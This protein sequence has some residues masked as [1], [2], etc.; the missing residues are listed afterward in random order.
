[1]ARMRQS[2]KLNVAEPIT[3]GN[4]WEEPRVDFKAPH[5]R[6]HSRPC[7]GVHND[8][9]SSGDGEMTEHVDLVAGSSPPRIGQSRFT[10]GPTAAPWQ[11]SAPAALRIKMALD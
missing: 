3:G 7:S 8:G 9:E 10:R 11:D 2:S 5:P 4:G 1:M 6:D